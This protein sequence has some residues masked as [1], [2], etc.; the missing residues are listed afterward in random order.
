M[1]GLDYSITDLGK[2]CSNCAR[3][4]ACTFCENYNMWSRPSVEKKTITRRSVAISM[5]KMYPKF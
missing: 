1:K 5:A 3:K 2:N 4:A